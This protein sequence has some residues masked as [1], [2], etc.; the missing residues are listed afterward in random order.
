M[1]DVKSRGIL[2]FVKNGPQCKNYMG[3]GGGGGCM[4]EIQLSN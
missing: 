1:F 4:G 2:F 3:V